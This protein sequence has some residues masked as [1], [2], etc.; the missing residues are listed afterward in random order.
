MYNKVMV[1]LD[2]SELAESVFPHVEST[3]KGCKSSEL[4]LTRV[5][6]P[7]T[8]PKITSSFALEELKKDIMDI[9]QERIDNAKHYLED[10]SQ[11]LDFKEIKINIDVL[12]GQAA[13]CLVEFAIASEVDVIIIATHGRSG[14]LR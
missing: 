3:V 13:D 14:A 8:V 9:E 7:V 4:F 12:K 2:G 11:R 1:P 5:I 6:E 10:I